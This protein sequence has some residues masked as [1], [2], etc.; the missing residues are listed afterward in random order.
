MNQYLYRTFALGAAT[1]V[2]VLFATSAQADPLANEVPKFAQEPMINT[3]ILNSTGVVGFYQGHDEI[4][5]VY[6]PGNNAAQPVY[7][8]SFMADDFSDNV[9]TPVVHITW[10]GSYHGAA[11]APQPP[12]QQ[13][14]IAFDS[15]NAATPGNFSYPKAPLQYEI[16]NSGPLT[17]GSGTFTET[18]VGGPDINGDLIYKYNAE[19]A[20]PFP[21]TAGVVYWLKIAAVVNVPAGTPVPPPP[22][23]TNWGWHNRDYTIQDLLAA[24]V[25]PG[26]VN[27]GTPNNQIWHFQDDAVQGRL[28]YL[29]AGAS[30]NQQII[31]TNPLPQ[32]YVDFADGPAGIGN[33]SKDL[34]FRLYTQGNVPEPGTCVLMVFGMLGVFATRRRK[35]HV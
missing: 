12:V 35:R 6:G 4:S 19:L 28:A 8:G 22:G 16:V 18:P 24:P 27:E 10:W 13:F 25:S 33:H 3:Q 7:Q 2:A 26:E 32:N 1:F 34:A 9:S 20:N 17:P 31:Q 29:P 21:E 30:L 15:D 5:T 11:T 14:L 23:T